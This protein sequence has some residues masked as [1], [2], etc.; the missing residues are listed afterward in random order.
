MKK[1]S[2]KTT[3]KIVGF[4]RFYPDRTRIRDF[5]GSIK[6]LSFGSESTLTADL[7]IEVESS[8]GRK[9]VHFADLYI[10]CPQEKRLASLLK[11]AVRR[12]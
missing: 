8:D 1:S 6:T 9:T 10:T 11:W 3:I 7:E 5:D 4:T 12:H 2:I